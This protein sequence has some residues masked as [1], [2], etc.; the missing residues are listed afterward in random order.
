MG[1]FVI[2]KRAN[3]EFQFNLKA[4]NGQ[5]ILTS[6]GYTTKAACL[7]GIESVKT[8]SQNDG[9]FDKLESKSGKP[10]F[11]LKATNGQII[12]SS[13]MYEST[14]A[15]DNGIASVKTNAPEAATDDQTA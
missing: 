6:E 15:R 7:N 10:Y 14:A 8:N 12:G 11:N 4:G 9:K 1:K 2:T 13:E 5:T 3:G